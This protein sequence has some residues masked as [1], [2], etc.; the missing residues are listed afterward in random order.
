MGMAVSRFEVHLVNLDPTVGSEIKKIRPGLIISP[1]ESSHSNRNYRAHD[2]RLI[3]VL[4]EAV[5]CIL[6]Y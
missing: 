3:A 6:R 2:D 4:G 5:R 1:N